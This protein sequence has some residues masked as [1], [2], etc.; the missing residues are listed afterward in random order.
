LA[1]GLRNTGEQAGYLLRG[2]GELAIT[3]AFNTVAFAIGGY[4]I[5]T[6]KARELASTEKPPDETLKFTGK[7]SEVTSETSIERHIAA[8]YIGQLATSSRK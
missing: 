3:S 4:L 5:I 6:G 8:G 2:A 7:Q 1:E